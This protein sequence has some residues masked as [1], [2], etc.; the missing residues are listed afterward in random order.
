MGTSRRLLI[1][2]IAGFFI[3]SAPSQ[4]PA[5]RP[6]K[7]V[8]SDLE[9]QVH[10]RQLTE[11]LDAAMAKKAAGQSAE[12][13]AASDTAVIRFAAALKEAGSKPDA[14]LLKDYKELLK[15][16]DSLVDQIQTPEF[17]S[18]TPERDFLSEKERPL[19][20]SSVAS[21]FSFSKSVATIEG[22]KFESRP[23]ITGVVSVLPAL[24]APWH[25]LAIDFEFTIVAGELDLYLRYWPDAKPFAIRLSPQTDFEIG[26][27][28]RASIRVQGSR[29]TFRPHGQPEA[30]DTLG[31]AISRTGGVG[32]GV[33]AGSRVD[34]SAFKVKVLR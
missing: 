8:V 16:S 7:P 33:R 14:S 30:V 24:T 5:S 27:L 22:V 28:Y 21:R 6:A 2:A 17:E 19:W 4:D 11:L 25:D 29:V 10:R 18:K 3:A 31:I 20:G 1:L 23:T 34:V 12:A 26:K 15:L 32:F 9:R 13:L